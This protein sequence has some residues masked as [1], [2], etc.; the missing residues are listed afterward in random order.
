MTAENGP[1]LS[2]FQCATLRALGL[3]ADT[4]ARERLY[5]EGA[6]SA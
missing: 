1:A 4:A 5:R 2:S 6:R 3:R